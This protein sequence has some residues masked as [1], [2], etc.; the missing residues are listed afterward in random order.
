[1]PLWGLSWSIWL[2]FAQ[3]CHRLMV[4]FSYIFGFCLTLSLHNLVI[5]LVTI[6]PLLL[7][8]RTYTVAFALC[9]EKSGFK[10]LIGKE[11]LV[12]EANV[13]LEG[14]SLL[15]LA[16]LSNYAVRIGGP[17]H[18]MHSPSSEE[19]YAKL[20]WVWLKGRR[21]TWKTYFHNSCLFWLQ[22]SSLGCTWF[23]HS[24]LTAHVILEINIKQGQLKH[25]FMSGRY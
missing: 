23:Y 16:F 25:A 15:T 20:V 13:L 5:Y 4:S 10:K 1:M 7:A 9:V 19:T 24:E 17:W 8:C 11:R 3:A 2:H 14:P 18:S 6:Y 12:F 21:R 22:T